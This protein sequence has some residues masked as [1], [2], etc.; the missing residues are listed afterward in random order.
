MPPSSRASE[1]VRPAPPQL[2]R[3]AER[4]PAF[5]STG[6]HADVG[7][8]EREAAGLVR[9]LDRETSEID[10][11]D[12][13]WASARWR[14]RRA[15]PEGSWL[16]SARRTIRMRTPSPDTASS[17][18]ARGAPTT[19][20]GRPRARLEKGVSAAS[21][22]AMRTFDRPTFGPKR[23][24]QAVVE[25]RGVEDEAVVALRD[26]PGTVEHG[27]DGRTAR[28]PR[29]ASA[30]TSTSSAMVSRTDHRIHAAR[31]V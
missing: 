29:A 6:G 11:A 4:R 24:E 2:A 27:R 28:E 13:E 12:R 22:A 19:A 26:R 1:V 9:E 20:A 17:A 15:M 8:R 31:A 16:P 7:Q 14:R 23:F 10:P 18:N 3:T 5:L 25:G 30:A 21:T